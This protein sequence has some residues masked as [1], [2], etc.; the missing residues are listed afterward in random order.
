M[1]ISE[2]KAY[3]GSS[4]DHQSFDTKHTG[5]NSHTFGYYQSERHGVFFTLNPEFA[6]LYGDVIEYELNITNTYNMDEATEILS[7]FYEYL[8]DKDSEL[9]TDVRDMLYSNAKSWSFFEDEVGEEFVK[10]LKSLGFDSATFVEYNEDD[11][12]D[13][14]KSQT[15]VVFNPSKI[16]KHDQLELN[17]YEKMARLH[18]N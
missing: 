11:S 16:I 10:Y 8:D 17:L 2:L 9:F 3:H 12:G 14:I 18:A 7:Q 13:E 15:I 1:K 5:N 4:N 6:A